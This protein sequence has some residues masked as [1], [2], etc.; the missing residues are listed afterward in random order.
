MASSSKPKLEDETP[1][2]IMARKRM[3]MSGTEAGNLQSY[4]PGTEIM[5]NRDG[6]NGFSMGSSDPS[7]QFRWNE[8]TGDYRSHGGGI[9]SIAEMPQMAAP[10]SAAPIG[11]P[12]PSKPDW[13]D[14]IDMTQGEG[15]AGSGDGLTTDGIVDNTGMDNWMAMG[16]Q[17]QGEHINELVS[18]ANWQYQVDPRNQQTRNLGRYR[19]PMLDE[20]MD[21]PFSQGGLLA[22]NT[23]G[24]LN[25]G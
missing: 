9:M 18:P 21:T 4:T 19:N 11:A 1:E 5:M 17:T 2:E 22:L 14:D 3:I 12:T 15:S 24:L 10:E 13:R 20:W 6:S 7:D 23:G 25:N 8:K 16:P